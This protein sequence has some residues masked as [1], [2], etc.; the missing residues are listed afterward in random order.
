[1]DALEEAINNDGIIGAGNPAYLIG[2]NFNK[3][4]VP[5]DETKKEMYF[6][7]EKLVKITN[8]LLQDDHIDHEDRE[9]LASVSEALN[10]GINFL[11]HIDAVLKTLNKM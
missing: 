5:L 9:A 11:E 3:K 4:V 6:A 1:M 2:S 7:Q 8:N 10:K